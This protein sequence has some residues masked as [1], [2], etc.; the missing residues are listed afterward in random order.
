MLTEP[1]AALAE[2]STFVN[3]LVGLVGMARIV[4][5]LAVDATAPPAAADDF[6]H[7]LLGIASLGAAVKR[8]P[9]PTAA[10]LPAGPDRPVEWLR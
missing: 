10:D 2:Q 5:A 7:L 4:R 6:V 3:G 9:A 1:R 8:L